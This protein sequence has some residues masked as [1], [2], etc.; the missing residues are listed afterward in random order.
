MR[1]KILFNRK[2][3]WQNVMKSKAVLALVF[4]I[5][6]ILNAIFVLLNA[7]SV[8]NTEL[9]DFTELSI[10]NLFGMY[11]IPIVVALCLLGYVFKR[12]SVDFINSMP[13]SR[14]EIYVTN[15][16]G[17]IILLVLMQAISTLLI[18]V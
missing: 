9:I 10:I 15:A 17:G 7:T 3:F 8:E 6:P 4:G 18:F 11:V 14:R 13:L 12:K 5:I 16:T 2:Y 1:L